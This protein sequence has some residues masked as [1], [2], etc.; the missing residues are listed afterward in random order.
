MIYASRR[1]FFSYCC[2]LPQ[3]KHNDDKDD[4]KRGGATRSTTSSQRCVT[5]TWSTMM[6]HHHYHGQRSPRT[7]QGG[8]Q[9]NHSLSI[10]TNNASLPTTAHHVPRQTHPPQQSKTISN[11]LPTSSSTKA[12]NQI[13]GLR[14]SALGLRCPGCG[15]VG[16]K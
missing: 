16:G 11:L 7:R 12:L 15:C 5:A 8:S 10:T 2:G 13:P 6:A 9:W 3:K 1:F 4:R 14:P